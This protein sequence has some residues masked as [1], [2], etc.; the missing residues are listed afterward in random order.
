MSGRRLSS[1]VCERV[2]GE[3]LERCLVGA[4][5]GDRADDSLYQVPFDALGRRRRCSPA[6]PSPSRRRRRRE[7]Q[8][9]Q[10]G[11]SAYEVG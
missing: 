3:A 6:L 1:Q 10:L 5:P 4:P 7:W 11:A 9:R 2:F 8:L